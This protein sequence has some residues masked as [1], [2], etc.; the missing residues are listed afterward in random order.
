MIMEIIGDI[1]A[2]EA[3]H[4]DSGVTYTG[5]AWLLFFD[6]RYRGSYNTYQDA[7]DRAKEVY[8]DICKVQNVKRRLP[9][10]KFNGRV[11]TECCIFKIVIDTPGI[12]DLQHGLVFPS[13]R[14][15]YEFVRDMLAK[16]GVNV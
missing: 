9:E 16:S 1:E 15:T 3:Q 8:D 7:V 4:T 13:K 11:L 2:G 5:E 14:E 12:V 10:R 6:K